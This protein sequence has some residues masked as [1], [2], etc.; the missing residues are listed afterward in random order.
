MV[1]HTYFVYM[2][3]GGVFEAILKTPNYRIF[4]ANDYNLVSE[5]QNSTVLIKIDILNLM[6]FQIGIIFI[7]L[8]G[9][10]NRRQC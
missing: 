2:Y 3:E 5:L 10:H 1:D 6:L 7:M 8:F 9:V 4:L